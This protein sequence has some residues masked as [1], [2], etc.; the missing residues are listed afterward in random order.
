M[1]RLH[2]GATFLLPD[3]ENPDVDGR[4]K[5][6]NGE[7][8][9]TGQNE[10]LRH[11]GAVRNDRQCDAHQR[12]EEDEGQLA[13]D[14]LEGKATERSACVARRT[15]S[16]DEGDAFDGRLKETGQLDQ[17]RSDDVE[18][19]AIGEIAE[20]QCKSEHIFVRFSHGG[21]DKA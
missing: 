18:V 21:H 19:D 7:A 3:L 14:V 1:K 4:V 12:E 13:V 17:R 15:S 11:G 2:E 9:D 6:A 16:V 5:G 8:V 10:H 20:K